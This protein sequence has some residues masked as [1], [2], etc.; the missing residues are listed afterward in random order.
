MAT[1]TPLN[2]IC[3][4]LDIS[5]PTFRSW[6]QDPEFVE[7]LQNLVEKH[8]ALMSEE[9]L[10]GELEALATVRE[11][12]LANDTKGNPDW[13]ARL[14]AAFRLLDAAGRR[15]K[16]AEKSENTITTVGSGSGELAEALNDP[17]V[18]A[19]LEEKFS[20]PKLPSGHTVPLSSEI[21]IE[22]QDVIESD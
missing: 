13:D 4:R 10:E 14:R 2:E 21:V 9:L 19:W 12:L 18:R 1:A 8:D 7:A 5:A 11:G 22:A 6:R 3:R 15:G 20:V 17:A 16:P